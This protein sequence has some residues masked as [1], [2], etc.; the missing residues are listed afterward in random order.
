MRV[1]RNRGYLKGRQRASRLMFWAGLLCFVAS[2]PIIYLVPQF[3]FLSY[4]VLFAGIILFNGGMQQMTKW[5]RSP[6]PDEV[7]DHKLRRFNDRYTMIHFPTIPQVRPMPEHVLVYPG[8][9][10]VITTREI[11]ANVRVENDRWTR[12]SGRLLSVLTFGGPALGNPTGECEAQQEVLRQFLEEN[13]LPGA[14]LID[15]MIV[16]LN[17]RAQV[18]V[19]S[20]DLTVVTADEVTNAVRDLGTEALLHSKAREQIINALTAGEDIEGPI[21]L[22]TRD[23]AERGAR[24]AR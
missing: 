23:V 20:S 12:T 6:R 18:D 8:G 15:G 14:D 24:G 10:L 19:V 1:V 17:P 13:D 3:W 7:L 16:F 9:L 2:F 11:A 21:S 4:V 22:P 5:N